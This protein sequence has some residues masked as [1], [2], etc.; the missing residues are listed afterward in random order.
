ML[1]FDV[2]GE[3]IYCGSSTAELKVVNAKYVERACTHKTV[4]SISKGGFNEIKVRNDKVLV[5]CAGW[6]K[7]IRLYECSS[8]RPMA[9]LR[10]HKGAVTGLDFCPSTGAI[11]SSSRDARIGIWNVYP[12]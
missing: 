10:H 7:R 9:I 5:A 3:D 6:D 2:C 1:C 11:A 12:V 8:S 4:Q